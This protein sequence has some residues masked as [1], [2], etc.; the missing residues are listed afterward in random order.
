VIREELARGFLD[1]GVVGCGCDQDEF[2]KRR[3]E[4]HLLFDLAL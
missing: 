1:L 2:L 4:A 3:L